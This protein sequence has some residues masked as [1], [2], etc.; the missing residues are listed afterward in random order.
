MKKSEIPFS[1][2]FY[3]RYIGLVED[4]DIVKAL[5]KHTLETTFDRGKMERLGTRV[6]EEGKWTIKNVV[7]HVLD[8]ER[9][10]AYRALR[11]ARNDKTILPGFD[12]NAFGDEANADPRSLDDLMEEASALR[13]SSVALFK[14]FTPE[15][16]LRKGQCSSI[17]ISV[18][19]LGFVIV[20]H[21]LHHAKV[22]S[23][24]YFPLL[25]A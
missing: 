11:I 14:S 1:P 10:M 17:Q 7:Q 4:I 12:E 23:E 16:L 5:Q 22:I 6:Y 21:M 9:I 8:T 15:M 20:G 25:E 18:L 19:A 3:D 13:A 2:V 24:R